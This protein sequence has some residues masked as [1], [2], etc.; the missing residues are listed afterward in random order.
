MRRRPPGPTRTATL[1]PYA[2]LFRSPPTPPKPP[3]PPKAPP[4]PAA[5]PAPQAMTS[6]L[7]PAPP[8]VS[9]PPAPPAAPDGAGTFTFVADDGRSVP[10]AGRPMTPRLPACTDRLPGARVF[11]CRQQNGRASVRERGWP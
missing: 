1:I 3:K 4:P 6:A 8:T 5:P 9:G 7:P 10:F 2:T 11:V